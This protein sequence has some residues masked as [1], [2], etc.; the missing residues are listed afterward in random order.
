MAYTV[1]FD[2]SEGCNIYR[3]DHTINC[4]V[5]TEP[6]EIGSDNK[7]AEVES[8]DAAS[9]DVSPDEV[10]IDASNEAVSFTPSDGTVRQRW[11]L[12]SAVKAW[13]NSGFDYPQLVDYSH[14]GGRVLS[15][16]VE[17]VNTLKPDLLLNHSN[18]IKDVVGVVENAY[19]EDSRDIPP[20]INADLVIDSELFPKE[21]K[22]VEKGIYRNG[23]IGISM[24]CKPSHPKMEFIDFIQSQ[25]KSIDGELVRWIP[26]RSHEVRHMA[27]IPAGTGA[28]P[29]AGKRIS[30]QNQ[31]I[32][33]TETET[34]TDVAQ[35]EASAEAKT[36]ITSENNEVK[37]KKTG[38]ER[39]EGFVALLSGLAEGLGIEVALSEDAGIPEGLSDRLTKKVEKLTS[40]AEKYNKLCS[41]VD[42]LAEY[43]NEDVVA[44]SHDEMFAALKTRLEFARH[45]EKLVEHYRKD[46]M[47]WFDAS[48]A[49]LGK[50]DLSDSEK[51]QRTRIS[52]SDDLDYLEDMVAE[53][54]AVAEAHF[55]VE[56]VSEGVD[57]PEDKA[58]SEYKNRDIESSSKRIFG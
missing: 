31:S 37:N 7:K 11:R 29:N 38:G 43:L 22:C 44:K 45:G 55:T 47:K 57:L 42:G 4:S 1:E 46:A 18:D 49:A 32:K 51:R 14:E 15:G 20:G 9:D 21:A 24:D 10:P 36:E 26:V 58:V 6:V 34:V 48:K 27:I 28:D 12:I 50:S 16:A 13:P 30:T 5:R 35:A 23:S 56:R 33:D 41:D 8:E 52:K 19:W 3:F 40:L 2:H 53:Y 17:S 25:G 39:M 54:R